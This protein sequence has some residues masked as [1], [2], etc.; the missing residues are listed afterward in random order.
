VV[1]ALFTQW[2]GVLFPLIFLSA[3]SLLTG[4]Y[5]VLSKATCGIRGN[6]SGCCVIAL[7]A[8]VAREDIKA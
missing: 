7:F 8:P 5:A 3:D 1:F 6:G 4:P 2:L